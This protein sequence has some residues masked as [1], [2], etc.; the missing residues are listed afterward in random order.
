MPPW[1]GRH[2]CL[3]QVQAGQAGTSGNQPYLTE[4]TVTSRDFCF[5]HP[6]PSP[7]IGRG[8]WDESLFQ[9]FPKGPNASSNALR[10]VEHGMG[11]DKGIGARFPDFG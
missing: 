3:R 7:K 4:I 1:P 2:L 10:M 9:L 8:V 5:P 11:R 6:C